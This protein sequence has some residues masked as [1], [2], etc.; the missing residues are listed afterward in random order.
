[1][2]H[3]KVD[4]RAGSHVAQFQPRETLLVQKLLGGLDELIVGLAGWS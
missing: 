2:V 4:S 1:M 3:A